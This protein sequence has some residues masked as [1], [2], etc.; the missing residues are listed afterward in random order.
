MIF[1]GVFASDGLPEIPMLFEGDVITFVAGTPIA[2]PAC[3]IQKTGRLAERGDAQKPDAYRALHSTAAESA[4]HLSYRSRKLGDPLL[5]ILL[6]PA[7]VCEPG[8][9]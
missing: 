5:L 4:F 1:E 3:Q 7:L 6:W 8:T 9:H 2:H